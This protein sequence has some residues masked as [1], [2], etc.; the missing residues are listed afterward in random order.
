MLKRVNPL[1]E[2]FHC[3]MHALNLCAAAGCKQ[4]DVQNCMTTVNTATSFFNMSAK[5]VEAPQH[6]V[7]ENEPEQ[8][9]KRLVTLCEIRFL[10]R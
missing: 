8:P 1:C 9:R 7:R 6:K 3:A 2:Y 10:E 4:R 5:R